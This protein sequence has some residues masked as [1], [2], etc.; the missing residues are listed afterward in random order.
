[1]LKGPGQPQIPLVRDDMIDAQALGHGNRLILA[2]IVD[3]QRL[4]AVD[5]G[6]TRRQLSKRLRQQ[7]RFI[8]A[9]NL[10][11]QLHKGDCM[12]EGVGVKPYR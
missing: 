6:D 9:G 2:A 1:M 12:E 4:N 8:K 5:A 10:D 7:F 3:H 11:N